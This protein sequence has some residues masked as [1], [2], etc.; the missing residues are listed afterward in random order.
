VIESSPTGAVRMRDSGFDITEIGVSA[1]DGESWG[2][3][4]RRRTSFDCVICGDSHGDRGS[5]VVC[6]SDRLD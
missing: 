5:A 6:C 4:A 2:D 1:D 3:L